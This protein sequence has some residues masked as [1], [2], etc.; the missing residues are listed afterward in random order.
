MTNYPNTQPVKPV[1]FREY[2]EQQGRH[3]ISLA[4]AMKRST[5]I[6]IKGSRIVPSTV[7][8]PVFMQ[9]VLDSIEREGY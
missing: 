9:C 3:P 5:G 6:S 4:L 7:M 2:A 1:T 8:E